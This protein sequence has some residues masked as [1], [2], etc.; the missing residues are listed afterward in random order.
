MVVTLD[1]NIEG[2]TRLEAYYTVAGI[3]GDALIKVSGIEAQKECSAAW[4]ETSEGLPN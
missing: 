1:W 3:L 4:S 2:L